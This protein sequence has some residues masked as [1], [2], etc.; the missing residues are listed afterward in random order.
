MGCQWRKLFTQTLGTGSLPA[1][2]VIFQV[3]DMQWNNRPPAVNRRQ[4]LDIC[5]NTVKGRWAIDEGDTLRY[6]DRWVL[7]FK[8]QMI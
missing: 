6:S 5:M 3:N 4:F 7:R 8:W 1:A 2:L